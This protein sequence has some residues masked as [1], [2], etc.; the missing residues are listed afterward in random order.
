V[1]SILFYLGKYEEAIE[2]FNKAIELDRTNVK[3]LN[4]KASALYS[5]QRGS[6]ALEYFNNV[7]ERDSC[8]VTQSFYFK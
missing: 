1:G 7:I 8:L 2:C 4:N 3:F 5:L 6:E